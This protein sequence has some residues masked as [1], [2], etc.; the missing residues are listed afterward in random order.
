M[1]LCEKFSLLKSP[2][3]QTC[4][5][6]CSHATEIIRHPDWTL[7]K[8]DRL[9]KCIHYYF[10]ENI[11]NKQPES[12][13][14]RRDRCDRLSTISVTIAVFRQFVVQIDGKMPEAAVELYKSLLSDFIEKCKHVCQ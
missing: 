5:R 11:P 6:K 14:F 2:S 12:Q 3:D 1:K 7:G 13:S 4:L 9:V 8:R 10:A